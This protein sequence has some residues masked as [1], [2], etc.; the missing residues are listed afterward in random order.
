[1]PRGGQRTR[2]DASER[3][4]IATGASGPKAGLI[5][6]VVG[7]GDEIVPDLA[8]K[9]P[10]RGI[11]VSADKAALEKAVKKNL[12]PRGAKRSV[13]T[14]ERLAELV[15]E[16][17]AARV[18]E[19]LSLARKAGQAIAGLEKVK[20]LLE[21]ED[22]AC[23]FQAS[24][25]SEREKRRLRPPEGP[26]TYFDVLSA[27][28]LGLAFGRDRVIHA[29]LIAGGLGELVRYESARLTGLRPNRG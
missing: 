9:L 22:A 3:R 10:G 6:F 8:E 26:N 20:G 1:M 27:Q 24:D 15:T 7:P 5:R 18:I 21:T 14:D 25:G 12:F 19:V 4:C 11:W 23:L 16:R 13:R 17:L 2:D 28:E 29:A